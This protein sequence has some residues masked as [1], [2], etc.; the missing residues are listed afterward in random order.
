MT[1]SLS[2]IAREIS[3]VWPKP[4]FAAVP[5][6]AAMRDLESMRDA[7]GYDNARSI[8]AYFLSNATTWK[9]DDARRIKAELK[10][11]LKNA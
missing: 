5:Y 10:G 7:Y 1:R 8:V 2:A 3:A 4:Y 9:G 6:L 11:M